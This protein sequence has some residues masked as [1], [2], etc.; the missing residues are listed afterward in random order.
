MAEFCFLNEGEECCRTRGVNAVD[1]WG[2]F[3]IKRV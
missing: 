2:G 3:S 1:G